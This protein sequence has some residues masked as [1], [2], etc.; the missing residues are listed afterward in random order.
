MI[1]N[2]VYGSAF[3]SKIA[4][5]IIRIWTLEKPTT[6][7]TVLMNGFIQVYKTAYGIEKEN[8]RML[9]LKSFITGVP[10]CS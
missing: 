1:K 3:K 6:E 7:K 9:V 5:K 10:K 4:R 2:G 8:N